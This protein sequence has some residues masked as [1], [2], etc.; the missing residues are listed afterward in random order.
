MRRAHR[1]ALL[2]VA[3][4]LS[5][6][7]CTSEKSGTPANW[8]APEDATLAANRAGL[9]MLGSEMLQVHYHAH[10]DVSVR[11]NKITVPA[12]LGIDRKRQTITAL[13]THDTTGIV[14]I[15]SAADIPF[16]LGQF[17]T[18]GVNLSQ[19][20]RSDRSPPAPAKRFGSTATA[21]WSRAI[22]RRS[23]SWPTTR[24]WS[25][26][27]PPATSRPCRRATT[28]RKEPDHM[29]LEVALIEIIPGQEDTF[30]ASFTKARPILAGTPGCQTIR[31]T[32][33]VES[34]SRFVLLVEWDTVE[35]HLQN[36][37]ETDRFLQWRALIGPHFA[38][39]PERRTLPHRLVPRC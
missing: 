35:A 14:H 10:V 31:M 8:S 24:S 21:S 1:L 13:H 19:P 11:G 29:V 23:G 32:R 28:S 15:E 22:R 20:L 2:A 17:F 30:V 12:N 9:P 39:P 37:R 36:F 25:G 18:N 6:A 33:G 38:K 5:L 26:S 7:A 27:D 34:P 16:T 3:A 4:T